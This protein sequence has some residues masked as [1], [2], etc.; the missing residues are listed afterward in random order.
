MPLINLESDY[1]EIS[2]KESS[3]KI[4]LMENNY[5]VIQK[6]IPIRQERAVLRE[7][8]KRR[9]HYIHGK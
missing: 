5:S 6:L 7:K 1:T 8:H 2:W 3:I 9:L 4:L